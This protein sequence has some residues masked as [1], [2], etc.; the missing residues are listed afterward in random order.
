MHYALIT[1]ATQDKKE[2]K[3][4]LITTSTQGTKGASR[5][6][7]R[8]QAERAA[9]GVIQAALWQRVPASLRLIRMTI[10]EARSVG[11]ASWPWLGQAAGNSPLVIGFWLATEG[12]QCLIDNCGVA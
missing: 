5:S 12:I 11:R 10:F 8:T 2:T 3:S 9:Q 7:S 1:T 6:V 4:A